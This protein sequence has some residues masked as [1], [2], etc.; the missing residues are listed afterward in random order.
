MTTRTT[1]TLWVEDRRAR[2][3]ILDALGS[4]PIH[5]HIEQATADQ[6]DRTSGQHTARSVDLTSTELHTIRLSLVPDWTSTTQLH[7]GIGGAPTL[8]WMLT[9]M[10][11]DQIDT[12]TT[13][14]MVLSA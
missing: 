2:R 10:I 7:G 14:D 5:D 3:I 8:I 11:I 13:G 6:P 9:D 1:H 4:G 12:L